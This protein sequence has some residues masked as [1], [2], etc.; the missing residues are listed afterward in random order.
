MQT[1]SYQGRMFTLEAKTDGALP[2]YQMR[3]ARGAHY[4]LVCCPDGLF[5]HNVAR[6]TVPPVGP[7]ALDGSM[8]R[9]AR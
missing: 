9:D 4:A 6:R 3:G 1:I 2:Y 7:L 8:L 5:L